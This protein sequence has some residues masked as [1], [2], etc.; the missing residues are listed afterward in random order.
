MSDGAIDRR[1]LTAI[2]AE[3]GGPEAAREI[4][5]IY[6]GEL[7][8][9]RDAVL[10]AAD[11]DARGRA[12]H[13]LGS[14][15]ALVGAFGL[16]RR[17]GEIERLALIGAPPGPSALEGLAEECDRVAAALRSLP[18]AIAPAAG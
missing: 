18:P 3:A 7:E 15:S 1:A 13:A 4:V 10:G 14:P 16:A 17:C 9:R 5:D 12:A 11:D 8:R 6:L 2:A